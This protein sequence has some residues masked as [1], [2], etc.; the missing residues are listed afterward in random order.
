MRGPRSFSLGHRRRF[1]VR[2]DA[3]PG[4]RQAGRVLGGG[5]LGGGRF[6][7]AAV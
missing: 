1:G 4:R 2:M 5:L 7:A 6:Q 3:Q